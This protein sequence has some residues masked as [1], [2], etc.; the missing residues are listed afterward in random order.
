MQPLPD[1][2]LDE[3]AR[4]AAAGDRQAL[5][6]LARHLT[7]PLYGLIRA[8]VQ[9]DV[10]AEDVLNDTW[11]AVIP[12]LTAYDAGRP[13]RAFVVGIAHNKVSD[14]WRRRGRRPPPGPLPDAL[15]AATGDPA[16]APDDGDLVR[17]LPGCWA[18]LTAEQRQIILYRSPAPAVLPAGPPVVTTLDEL[19]LWLGN[20]VPFAEV[21]RRLGRPE[22]DT[23]KL[24]AAFG[25]AVRRLLTCLKVLP[26]RAGD[27]FD[28]VERA[29]VGGE[30]IR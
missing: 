1:L 16:Q 19:C 2:Q 8:R 23:G 4:A 29:P 25:R 21:A 13:F 18:G 7:P 3:L 20:R 14:Y 9:S 28:G 17:R 22:A 5:E 27:E 15:V 26:G 6:A 30:R 11:A 12:A 24:R 10:D